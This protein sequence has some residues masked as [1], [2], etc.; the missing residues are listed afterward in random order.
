MTVKEL[1]LSYDSEEIGIRMQDADTE[2]VLIP[3]IWKTD[4]TLINPN[5]KRYACIAFHKYDNNVYNWNIIDEELSIY[6]EL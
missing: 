6:I 2:K 1:I 5:S 3:F 4:Y